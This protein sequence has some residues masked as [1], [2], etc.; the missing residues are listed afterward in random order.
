MIRYVARRVTLAI[1]TLLL[2]S[3]IIFF[4]VRLV[5]GD[6]AQL[7]L[8][9][10]DNPAELAR[11]R[12][13]MMLDRPIWEQFLGWLGRV[14]SGD[15]GSSIVQQRPVGDILMPAFGVTASLVIP[16]VTLAVLL[17]IPAGSFAARK[18]D[19]ALDTGIMALATTFLSIPSFWLGLIF[20]L[21]FGVKLDLFPVVGYVSLV[22]DPAE[23][24]TYLIMPVLAL[25]LIETGVLVRM[26]RSSTLDVLSLEYV[27]HARA[28]GLSEATVMRRH[29]LRNAIAPTWTMIGLTLGALLGGAVVTETVFTLPGLGRLMVD[30]IFARDYPLVQ[31]CMLLIT[32][33]YVVVNLLIEI[34]HSLFDPG[35]RHEG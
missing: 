30:S 12:S 26:V 29:V 34:S 4:M 18:K 2:A 11:L 25:A 23:G 33:V 6:P 31:G 35:A 1:P 7:M 5:P 15:L 32:S 28:K 9:E 13:Q 16:A 24:L 27:T 22:E 3:A 17:A 8:G 10:V 20:L 19:S 21:A 14:V